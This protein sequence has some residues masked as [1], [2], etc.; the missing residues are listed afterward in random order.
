MN[1]T[2]CGSI[3]ARDT[4]EAAEKRL[5]QLGHEVEHP[6]FAEAKLHVQLEK[7]VVKKRGFI[8]DHFKKID[9][10]D[11]VLIV[12]E[13]KA[14]TKNYIGGNTL[15]EMT[16]AYAQG[17]EIFLL[18]PIPELGYTDEIRGMQPIV[19]DGDVE[20]IDAYFAALPLAYLS[21]ESP[22]K[23]LAVSRAFRKAGV[24]VRI[25]GTKVESGV[26]EQPLSIDETYE[27][28]LNRQGALRTVAPEDAAYLVTI[29]SGQHP[30][31]KN[32]SLFGCA[33]IVVEPKGAAAKIGIDVDVEF[34]QA[35]LDKVPSQ[36]PDL[37]VLV[38]QEYGATLKDPYPY[39][40]NNKLTRGKML[41]G[42]VYNVVVQLG[43]D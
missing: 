8:D 40:T 43:A 26:N 28:A 19:L 24:P 14:G 42:A 17:L 6:N 25:G 32:H 18:N 38:Q 37:G 39:F 30:A 27:G 13:D 21:T 23:Q 34:P 41:E 12:N 15:M 20:K 35:M 1:I 16:Y 22:V 4:M 31:H 10:S 7:D 3:T 36:Y 11:A 29:E 9:A 33:V 2:I 5:K